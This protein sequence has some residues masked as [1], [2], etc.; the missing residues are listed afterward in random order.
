MNKMIERIERESGV[1]GLASILSGLSPT[2]LQ[3][4]M[5]AVYKQHASQRQPAQLLA[6][7][8]ESRFV[9]PA[10]VEPTRFNEWECVAFSSLPDGFE[11]LIL[12][13]VCP[14][15]TNSVVALVDQDWAIA[16]SRNTEV[17]S[18]AT[19]VMALECA[20]RRRDLLK[21]NSKSAEAVHLA[22][23]HRLVRTVRFEGPHSFAHFSLFGLCSAGRDQG[24]LQFELST[25]RTH[26]K[27]YL[28]ALR[29]FLGEGL[30]LELR[31][32]DFNDFDRKEM[33]E[34]QLL[35][36]IQASFKDVACTFNDA[37][38]TGRGYY[39]DVCFHIDAFKNSGERLN[40]ADGGAVDWTAK[41]L[42]N[43]K[44]RA[45]ISGIGSERVCTAFE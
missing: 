7:Y 31:L 44:E 24:N 27:F 45:I 8:E 22:A 21:Q 16:T 32:T 3:S 37:R 34:A 5:L 29:T 39:R 18:D 11:A 1:A 6:A 9:Q 43:G 33:L 19:N 38:T 41:L 15:G 30:K 40:V 14:L 23:S 35:A 42:S 4:L 12:S 20:K 13:P 25:L 28:K 2:D 10:A 36:P 26:I 17:V